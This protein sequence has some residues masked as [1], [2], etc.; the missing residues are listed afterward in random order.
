MNGRNEEVL[1]KTKAEI[2]EVAPGIK[3]NAVA[4]DVSTSEG[5][6]KLLEACPEPDILVNNNG[7]PPFKDFREVDR[8]SMLEGLEMNRKVNPVAMNNYQIICLKHGFLII[9]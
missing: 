1:E 3:I 6:L 8:D 5:R 4:C 7:G 9:F 2:L